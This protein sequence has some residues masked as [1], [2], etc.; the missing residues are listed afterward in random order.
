[1]NPSK[2]LRPTQILVMSFGTAVLSG[3]LLLWLPL[4]SAEEPLS[5]VDAL[6][7]ATSAVC[8]TG[9]TVVDTGTHFSLFGQLVI[10][11]LIQLGGLGIM[12]LGTFFIAAL[13]G[14][15]S[16]QNRD[17]ITQTISR[18]TRYDLWQLLKSVLL[19]TMTV[20]AIGAALLAIRFLTNMSLPTAL[21]HSVF[22]S[23]SAFCNAGFSLNANSFESYVSD[24]IVNLT[25]IGLIIVGGL[26]FVVLLDLRRLVQRNDGLSHAERR[27]SFHSRLTLS[28]TGALVLTGVVLFIGLEW[29]DTLTGLRWPD[30]LLASLFQSVTSRTAGFNTVPIGFTSNATLFLLIILMFIGGAPGSCAG[31]VKVT[32]FGVLFSLA[33]NRIRGRQDAV[34]FRRRISEK[35]VTE[36]MSI[37]TLGITVLVVFTFLLLAIEVGTKSFSYTQGTFIQ[38]F[39]EAVSAFG[40]VGLSTGI[41]PEL[42]VAGRLLVTLLMFIG[43]LGPLTIAVAVARRM[44]RPVFRYPEKQVMVG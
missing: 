2:K 28:F 43:R 40:T 33:I 36:S 29:T 14:R 25:L 35:S 11:A 13:G 18:D 38:L 15:L 22:H 21:Y 44:Q 1:M 31:G 20:E 26:G 30:K 10:L 19:L 27:L 32:T 34:I 5:L 17:L 24:W 7:T 37:L 16:W 8:V 23:V 12:T 39:F 9:L 6:F 3:T 42:S 4:A 41:T